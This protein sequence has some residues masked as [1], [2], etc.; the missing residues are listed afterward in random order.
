MDTARLL[1][2]WVAA[3]DGARAHREYLL[4]AARSTSDRERAKEMNALAVSYDQAARVFAGR[5]TRL[6]T[7]AA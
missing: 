6:Q 4:N 2:H 1:A 7:E 3:R 5:V